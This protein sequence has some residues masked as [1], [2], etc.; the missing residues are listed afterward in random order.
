[1]TEPKSSKKAKLGLERPIGMVPGLCLIR[2]I[3]TSGLILG[4][5]SCRRIGQFRPD[6]AR[7]SFL[8][9]DLGDSLT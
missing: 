1:M 6:K 7:P 8:R 9:F 4:A 5:R 3:V 2:G